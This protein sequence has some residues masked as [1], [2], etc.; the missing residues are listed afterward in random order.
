MN[1]IKIIANRFDGNIPSLKN[2]Y[3]MYEKLDLKGAQFYLV[4]IIFAACLP[5]PHR[6]K[7]SYILY[8]S[9]FSALLIILAVLE[10]YALRLR[11]VLAGYFYHKV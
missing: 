4:I 9:I 5:Q 10:S 8:S 2:I 7:I 3:Y 1:M 6:L 11:H